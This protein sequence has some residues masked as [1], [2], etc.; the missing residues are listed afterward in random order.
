MA[1]GGAG[2]HRTWWWQPGA[3]PQMLTAAELE[4]VL[5]GAS[6]WCHIRGWPGARATSRLPRN[7][8][9]KLSV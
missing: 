4:K 7:D 2:R 6:G 5:R 8:A 3:V 1:G 9:S